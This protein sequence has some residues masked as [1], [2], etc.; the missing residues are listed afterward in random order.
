MSSTTS[1]LL[2]GVVIDI[3]GG[4]LAGIPRNDFRIIQAD[5]QSKLS[6]CVCKAIDQPLDGLS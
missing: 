1:L 5:C 4:D 3:D 6:A 2:Q